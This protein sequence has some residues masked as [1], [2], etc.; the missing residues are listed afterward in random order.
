MAER[1]ATAIDVAEIQQTSN[2]LVPRNVRDCLTFYESETYSEKQQ[3][4]LCQPQRSAHI[5]PSQINSFR[6]RALSIEEARDQKTAQN[7]EQH[8]TK[9]GSVRAYSFEWG[10]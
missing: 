6:V 7:E 9:L 2:E 4:R 10:R 1:Q 3:E 5:K 8:D